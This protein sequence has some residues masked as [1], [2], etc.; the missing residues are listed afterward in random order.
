MS[1]KTKYSQAQSNQPLLLGFILAQSGTSIFGPTHFSLAR[2]QVVMSLQLDCRLW[3]EID[4]TW[5]YA[6]IKCCSSDQNS[7][8]LSWVNVDI[9]RRHPR[10]QCGSSMGPGMSW[11]ILTAWTLMIVS[12]VFKC[13]FPDITNKTMG[14]QHEGSLDY[15]LRMV[16]QINVRNLHSFLHIV[17]EEDTCRLSM[18]KGCR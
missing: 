2:L 11:R 9:A 13:W 4:S 3:P 16:H 15:C 18:G 6:S 12:N 5:A 10:P 1:S 7:N 8:G 14:E 17:V